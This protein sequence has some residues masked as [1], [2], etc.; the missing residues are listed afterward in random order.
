V[1]AVVLA[2]TE[3]DLSNYDVMPFATQGGNPPWEYSRE[4]SGGN[5]GA[6][7]RMRTGLL[8]R[9]EDGAVD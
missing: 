9:I 3:F 4:L 1:L 5:P 7:M 2:D 8:D 6:W